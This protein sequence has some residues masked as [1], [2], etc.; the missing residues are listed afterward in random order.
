VRVILTAYTIWR[1]RLSVLRRPRG[2]T[3]AFVRQPLPTWL[4][5]CDSTHWLGCLRLPLCL[6]DSTFVVDNI[7]REHSPPVALFSTR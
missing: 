4:R 7:R 5:Y 6:A 1:P 2:H 3:E